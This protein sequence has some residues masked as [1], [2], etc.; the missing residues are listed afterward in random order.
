MF[1]VRALGLAGGALFSVLFGALLA[2]SP[3]CGV[4]EYQFPEHTGDDAGAPSATTPTACLIDADCAL[5]M[6]TPVCDPAGGYCVECTS[7][8]SDELGRCPLG[9]Y[10]SPDL[11]CVVGCAADSDCGALSCDPVS[12]QCSGCESD[13]D[14]AP[15]SSCVDGSCAPGCVDDQT[16]PEGWSCCGGLCK[17]LLTDSS[18]CGACDQACEGPG[19]CIEGA[20]GPGPCEPGR[21]ECDGVAEN[22]CETDLIENP[23]SCGRCRAFC[24]SGICSGGACAPSECPAGFADCNQRPDDLCE[25]SLGTIE[26]CLVCGRACGAAHGV[27]ACTA[28]G[29]EIACDTGYGDCD[30]NV[31]TGCETDVRV[32]LEHCGACGRACENENGSTRCA[33][34]ECRPTCGEGFADCDGEPGNGCETDL[35]SSARHCGVCGARCNPANATGECVDGVCTAACDEGFADCN[36]L[37]DDGCE[38]DLSS[39]STCGSCDTACS[40]NGGTPLCD[41]ES[42]CGI[43][44]DPGRADCI[45]G[46]TD[47]CETNTNV[48]VLHC[49]ACKN[50]C[51]AAVGTPTCNDGECAVSTCTDP[52]AECDGDDSTPCET[53]VTD[54][55]D[56]C[57]GCGI[58]CFYPNATGICVNRTCTL[59]ECNPG[60]ADCTSALGCETPLGS[61]SNC[62][63]CGTTCTNAHG[64]TS[65]AGTPGD[66]ACAPVCSQGYLDC[67]N[68][69]DGCETATAIASVWAVAGR[70][71]ATLTWSAVSAA[72]GYVV[73]RATT[74]GGPYEEVATGVTSTTFLDTGLTNGTT[75]Y[76]VIAAVV[77]CGTGVAS[78]E[79][80][81]TP[82]AQLVAHYMFDETSGASAF[83][84][85]GNG[86]TANLS[87]ATFVAG[88]R[89]NA[90]R[91]A[92]GTQ[93]VNLP[94]GIVQGCTDLTIA[95]WVRLSS[96]PGGWARIFD[97]GSG[98]TSSLFLSP[99]GDAANVL[100]FAISTSGPENE[101]RLSYAYTFP[102]A[103]WKHVAVVLAGNTGRLYLDAAEVGQNTQLTLN[104]VD[105]GATPNNWLGDSQWEMDPTLDGS[106]DDLRISCRAYT[107]AEIVALTQ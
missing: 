61:P 92:G 24:S 105:L 33:D 53:D 26:N 56:N 75:Y 42:G 14:C 18:S 48:S 58:E 50:A 83:D 31:D 54:D 8:R 22:G 78:A 37:V 107:P 69:A 41:P 66:F 15:G 71:R 65:C 98:T 68:P 5:L 104:P 16:C 23:S 10:C 73:R 67:T 80:A 20:C 47:G 103:T 51:P 81:A 57:G 63:D 82:D 72:T 102:T 38:V 12:H 96:A 43:R 60:Y 88:R 87:G 70:G 86:R 84:A 11:H 36:G 21:G 77:A 99:R 106:L 100:R 4:P 32:T 3:G 34:G 25:T 28:N 44:C 76:Y 90:A 62:D 17:N 85:S 7:G 64:T 55:P 2:S 89:G 35:G 45:N 27:P 74:S 95:T 101:Q 39:P 52:Y 40:D 6:S 79:V 97:F 30:L 29:C 19:P 49:G 1:G 13:V 59:G 94:S 9:T 46:V 93:R 91:I